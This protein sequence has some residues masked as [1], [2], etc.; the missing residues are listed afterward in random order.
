MQKKIFIYAFLL[1]AVVFSGGCKKDNYPGGQIS[2]YIAIFDVRNLYKGQDVSLT[3]NNMSGSDYITGV[4]VS[5]HSGGNLPAGLLVVQDNRRLS[6]L[7]GIAIPLGDAAAD[8]VPGD[9]VVI[10]ATGG[11][12]KRV[13]GILQITGITKDKVNR[14][15]AGSMILANQIST[16][17]ILANPDEY[18]SSLSVIVK[19]GFDPLPAPGDVLAGD[20]ILNDGFGNITLHTEATAAF[21]DTTAPV[22]ANFYGIIFNTA[23]KDGALVPQLR[24]RKA[25]DVVVL[26]STITIAPVLITGFMSDVVKGS[27]ADGNYEYIQL[28]ATRDIDFSVTPFSVVTTNNANASTPTG[29]PA[30]GWA[31]GGLRTYKFNLTSGKAAKGTF[32]YV[33]GTAKMI[34]GEV[35]TDISAANWISPYNY[36]TNAGADFGTKTTNLLANSGNAFGMAVFEGTTVTVDSIPVDVIFISTGGSLYTA[37][38]P[39]QGYRI[40]N[41]DWYDVKNPVSLKD[42]PFYRSGSN[43]LA[44][45]YNTS[46]VGIFNMLGGEYRPS[47]GRWTTAR[48]Q[49]NITLTKTSALAEIEAEGSTKLK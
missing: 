29:Y 41:T 32:F 21:A 3:T 39:A 36:A 45:T 48:S 4:V 28:M 13:D 16:S 47:L 15:A 2:P 25:S 12:L 11:V 43:T 37:G 18:E 20:K 7:R 40:T 24:M 42:Q 26:S 6:K 5:D 10:K 33:G 31:T 22:L 49:H 44:L 27:K 8:F 46:D 30:K 9:S 35:S 14:V 17:T 34:N 23:G 1:V 19:G 38:P